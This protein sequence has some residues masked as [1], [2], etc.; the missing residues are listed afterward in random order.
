[1]FDLW[2]LVTL[3]YLV[4]LLLVAFSLRKLKDLCLT[5]SGSVGKATDEGETLNL[6]A[7]FY[8]W[9]TQRTMAKK[10]GILQELG[11]KRKSWHLKRYKDIFDR[12]AQEKAEEVA[13]KKLK[14][15]R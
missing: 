4:C 7:N 13:A 14:S 3:E 9:D 6:N 2:F 10:L 15:V 5:A 8:V 1:M 11:E 12:A